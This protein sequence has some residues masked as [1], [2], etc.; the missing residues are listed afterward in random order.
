MAGIV[1][2]VGDSILVREVVVGVD[3]ANILVL[4]SLVSHDGGR[5]F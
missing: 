2:V 5:W 4:S 1:G 3:D